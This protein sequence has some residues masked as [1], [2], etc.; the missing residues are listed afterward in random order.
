M[1]ITLKPF[2]TTLSCIYQT[3]KSEAGEKQNENKRTGEGMR[4]GVEGRE[5]FGCIDL[6]P[7]SRSFSFLCLDFFSLFSSFFFFK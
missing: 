1:T 4:R 5:L 2:G 7:S 6:S 3:K